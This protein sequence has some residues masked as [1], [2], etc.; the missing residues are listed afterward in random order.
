MC[1][2]NNPRTST[3]AAYNTVSNLRRAD[4]PNTPGSGA[5]LPRIPRY[6][7]SEQ[8][9]QRTGG[10]LSLQWRPDDNTNISL[11]LLY[12][13]YD[14]E[15]RDNYIAG[16]SLARNINNNG[17]PMTSI[18][19][20]EFD[21]NGSLVYGLFDGMDVRSEGLVDRFVSEFKQ[22]NLNID[23]RFSDRF[24]MTA[25]LG[26][27]NSSYDGT[28]RL[29]TFMDAIDTRGFGIDFRGG[30]SI[31]TL[32]FGFDVSNPGNFQYGPSPD[33]NRTVTGGFTTQ[34]KPSFNDTENT[35]IEVNF[36][37][38]A[39]DAVTLK[40]GA[41]NRISDFS[42]YQLNLVPANQPIRALPPG[43]SLASI[44]R[45]ISGVG[46]MF[47]HG[48]PN[49]WAAIDPDKFIDVFGFNSF[50]YCGIECGA[51]RSNIR[52]NVQSAYAMVA[53][54]FEQLRL[55][56][57]ADFGI[58]YV[59]TDQL[60]VGY[61]TVAAPAGSL[62]PAIGQRHVVDRSYDDMLPS[63]NIAVEITPDLL[64]RF[65]AAKVMS[66]PELSNL[67]PS[68]GV[69]ATTRT[70]NVNNPFLDPIRANTY[71][72]ALEWYFKPGSLLSVAYFHKDLQTYIQRVTEQV[73]FTSLG[74]PNSLLDNTPAQPSDI[75]TVG[76][77]S[78]TEGGPLDGV[79]FNAQAQLDF[80]RGPFSNLGVLANYTYVKSE[81][82]YFLTTATSTQ[83]DLIGLS[84]HSASGTLYYEDDRFSVRTTASY[85]GKY[86]RGIP[87]SPG[88]DLQGNDATVYVDASASYALTD[89]IKLIIEGQNLT[90]EQNRLFID[91]KREDTLFETRVGR[92]F[93]IGMTA[94]F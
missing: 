9:S 21:A 82:T 43:T 14:V 22:V 87:A 55:P 71:D 51:A 26:R 68:A 86:V 78:N 7:N 83:N 33:G 24:R 20:V 10:T 54:D 84:R 31:P 89:N 35:T 30:G 94:R 36:E 79:E 41:Q 16:L 6:I 15:R 40:F 23:H 38:N 5:F 58:R 59:S 39:S 67:T 52:E 63:A 69:T 29:Q 65:S 48:A 85:R 2:T 42:T 91:S 88:S 47:G 76:R 57:R 56:V 62:Y 17:Q 13:K 60:A 70:G 66:R 75:F 19:D 8:D 25:L 64:A 74:L 53:V 3:L 93:N 49:S 80:L 44:T 18:R 73:P 27:S 11:D 32:N 34:A 12:S 46:D 61:L 37:F 81:I 45:Q 28:L 92:T 90:D 77:F 72:A 4:L 1:S 50:S